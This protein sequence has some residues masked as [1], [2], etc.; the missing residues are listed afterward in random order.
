METAGALCSC[1]MTIPGRRNNT[2]NRARMP[3]V[4]GPAC[5]IMAQLVRTSALIRAGVMTCLQAMLSGEK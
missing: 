5:R 1:F 4:A 3:I 2:I